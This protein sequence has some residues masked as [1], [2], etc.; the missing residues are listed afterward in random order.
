MNNKLENSQI[1]L[2]I[3]NKKWHTVTSYGAKSDIIYRGNFF[4]TTY[5]AN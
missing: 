1:K 3:F 2:L 5:A 4:L